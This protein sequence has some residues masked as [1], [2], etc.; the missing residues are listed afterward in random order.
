M[1]ERCTHEREIL[2]KSPWIN[3]AVDR[4]SANSDMSEVGNGFI[5][6]LFKK[7][8]FNAKWKR[9]GSEEM[10]FCK[11]SHWWKAEKKAAGEVWIYAE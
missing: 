4:I 7:K 5:K 1:K 10:M 8:A 2:H 6:A 11:G 3:E 9:V